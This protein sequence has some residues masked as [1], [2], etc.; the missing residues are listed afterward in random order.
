M[1]FF[2]DKGIGYYTFD[3][4]MDIQALHSSCKSKHKCYLIMNVK[5]DS[6]LTID[7]KEI[8]V[9]QDTLFFLD[10]R[11]RFSLNPS[12]KSEIIIFNSEFYCI[13][14][15][16]NELTCDGILF[17]NIY[18]T[19]S[20]NIAQKDSDILDNL[21]SEIKTELNQGDYW[22]EEMIRTKLKELIITVSRMWL[23]QNPNQKGL[24]SG[25]DELSR[26]FSQLVEENFSTYHSV[27]DYAALLN[28]T[29]KTLNRKI[30]SEKKM[31]PNTFIK[32]RIVLQAKR[33]LSN[34][35]LTVKEI[36]IELG[37]QD[38]SYFVRLF[39]S[40]TGQTPLNFRNRNNK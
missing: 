29:A 20:I 25:E 35:M 9:K 16:D 5:A 7:F 19:P 40:Q 12:S 14:F 10:S 31:A 11:Q 39:R 38:Q 36:A 28:V 26:K 33:L 37:Y 18:D 2:G 8:G 27:S 15:H 32:N 13:A 24:G 34:T 21:F 17:N 22:T 23:N 3:S 4:F 6:V 1:R 30:V